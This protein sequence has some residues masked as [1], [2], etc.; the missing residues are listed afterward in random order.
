MN[1]PTSH[2]IVTILLAVVLP[3]GVILLLFPRQTENLVKG[4]KA[5]VLRY[6]DTR[7]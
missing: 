3:G 1:M 6:K 7:Q 2:R 5:R 4:V